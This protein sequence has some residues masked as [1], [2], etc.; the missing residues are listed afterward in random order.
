MLADWPAGGGGCM[1]AHAR[2]R[3]LL[4]GL[5]SCGLMT[6]I[7][8]ALEFHPSPECWKEPR[9]FH[10]GAPP[11]ELANRLHLIET[12]ASV[13]APGEAT[14][15]PDERHRFWV[16]NPDTSQPGP[17][18]AAVVV[19]TGKP[20]RPALFIEDV[21]GPLHPRW[22]NERL[23]FLRVP[24]GRVMFSD[25]IL[26]VESA[27]LR[28]HELAQDGR[29]AYEQFRE[30]CGG[31][32][33]CAADDAGAEEE[34]RFTTDAPIPLST[35]G[36]D[37][38]T[39]LLELP[40]VF[41]PPETGGVVA[42]EQ[43]RAVAIYAAPDDSTPP[44]TTL[45]ELEDFEYREFTYEGAAAVVYRQRPDWYEI[46]V[47]LPD[48]KKAWLRA[49][50]AGD[51]MPVGELLTGRLAYLNEHWDG[52]LWADAGSGRRSGEPS[53]LIAPS[54]HD[55]RAELAVRILETRSVGDGLW[56]RVETM[57]EN[58][59]VRADSP[60]VDRG[61][62]PAYSATGQ[63]VAWFFSRGC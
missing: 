30:A 62:I 51:F 13:A 40:T 16:R 6:G 34:K 61:W 24:W 3:S 15:A 10:S 9:I 42:A 27:T 1:N 22:L 36:A 38:L 59:C 12:P 21:S 20:Q 14:A 23:L 57:E 8:Q 48:R 18:G 44:I 60:V 41:G 2:H 53:R 35:P 39:G 5:L 29:A 47:R 25:L 28:Y 7:S 50:D 17:W 4:L 31:R 43:P 56:L 46:G 45:V 11:A 32:C 19:D 55:T 52:H 49:G 58:E 33:P 26:D 54:P 63:L 37:A